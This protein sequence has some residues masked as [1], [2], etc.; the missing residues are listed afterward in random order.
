MR[1]DICG[2]T[3]TEGRLC[4]GCDEWVDWGAGK[5]RF[6]ERP[7]TPAHTVTFQFD[8]T[9]VTGRAEYEYARLGSA[10][11]RVLTDLD[12]AMRACVKHDGPPCDQDVDDEMFDEVRQ[13]GILDA[14]NYWRDRLTQLMIEY[15]VPPDID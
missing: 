13:C 9:D 14:T 2:A 3:V 5:W 7:T 4:D 12:N 11:Y 10:F 8:L 1:C 6:D 15:D